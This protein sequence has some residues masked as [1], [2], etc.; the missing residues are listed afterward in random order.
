VSPSYEPAAKQA[1]DRSGF[2]P[3]LVGQIDLATPVD[4]AG[5]V[6]IDGAPYD[7]RSCSCATRPS[8]RTIE[9]RSPRPGQRRAA[10]RAVERGDR[11]HEVGSRRPARRRCRSRHRGWARRRPVSPS[12]SRLETGLN[13]LAAL[14]RFDPCVRLPHFDVL[15]V[16]NDPRSGGVRTTSPRSTP[17]VVASRGLVSSRPAGVRA[18]PRVASGDGAHRR[19]HR[20]RRRGRSR[21]GFEL[22]LGL[23]RRSRRGL[24]TGM[25][26]PSSRDRGA[27][28]RRAVPSGSTR[29]RSAGSSDDDR[30]AGSG[31]RDPLF[32]YTAGRSVRARHAFAPMGCVP[33]A[34]STRL[35][36]RNACAGR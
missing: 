15:V 8:V 20:R 10:R 25:M 27:G 22:G 36:Y 3:A 31:L 12:W 14:H 26:L 13:A 11:A 2:R 18:Q 7:E 23:S 24:L 32:P 6:G 28:A 35:R 34:V 4:L 21:L 5:G 30:F 16:D 9:S 29:F 19:V 1:R 17:P 33:S